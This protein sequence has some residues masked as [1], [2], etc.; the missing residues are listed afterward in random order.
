MENQSY[1][2]PSCNPHYEMST[3]PKRAPNYQ[4]LNSVREDTDSNKYME[5]QAINA[6]PSDFLEKKHPPDFGMENKNS[7]DDVI[8]QDMSSLR[9]RPAPLD[10]EFYKHSP[11]QP[12]YLTTSLPADEQRANFKQGHCERRGICLAVFLTV[13]VATSILI[14]VAALAFGI[15]TGKASSPA[16][17]E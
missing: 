2:K 13:L 8:Y 16:A 6:R 1:L 4:N 9:P 3:M 5:L 7:A 14:S 17:T 10:H 12:E 15:S 11:P